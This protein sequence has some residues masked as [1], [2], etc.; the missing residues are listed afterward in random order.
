MYRPDFSSE[1]APHIN[2]LNAW[3]EVRDED[4]GKFLL[5]CD[6]VFERMLLT[7]VFRTLLLDTPSTW[8]LDCSVGIVMGYVLD[9]RS[10]IHGM[11]K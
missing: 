5:R 4:E 10:S 6:A 7:Y 11:M 2:K 3:Y 8:I 9:Y 1:R